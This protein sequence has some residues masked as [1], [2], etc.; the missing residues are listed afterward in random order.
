M[1]VE[2]ITIHPLSLAIGALGALVPLWLK[3]HN[4]TQNGRATL[5]A[6]CA[7]YF[8]SVLN[9]TD[10][11]VNVVRSD[12]LT[13]LQHTTELSYI[14]NDF[15][16]ILANPQFAQFISGNELLIMLPVQLRRELVEHNASSSFALNKGSIKQLLNVYDWCCTLPRG[17]KFSRQHKI[18]DLANAMRKL[19]GS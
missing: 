16:A 5:Y 14:L 15:N 4:E 17:Y 11:S 10:Q 9:S 12:Q 6:L 3:E 1:A 8:V 18:K 19:A 7:R 2:P 13:K